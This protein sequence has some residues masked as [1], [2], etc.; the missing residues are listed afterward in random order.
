[1]SRYEGKKK[2]RMQCTVQECNEFLKNEEEL[3][4]SNF[5]LKLSEEELKVQIEKSEGQLNNA[6]VEL[7]VKEEDLEYEKGV[8]A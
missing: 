8:Q 1:M 5:K 3:K 4:L 6:L 2:Q 7:K